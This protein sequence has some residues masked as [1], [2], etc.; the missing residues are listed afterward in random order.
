MPRR[1]VCAAELSCNILDLLRR[2][3]AHW[4]HTERVDNFS[5]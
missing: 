1:G 2:G 4:K 3:D 5:L